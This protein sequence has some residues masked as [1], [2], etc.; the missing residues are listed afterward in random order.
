[1]KKLAQGFPQ[2]MRLYNDDLEKILPILIMIH[3]IF[4]IL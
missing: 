2:R 1:M 3:M 4:F